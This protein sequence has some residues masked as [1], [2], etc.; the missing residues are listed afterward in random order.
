MDPDRP[1]PAPESLRTP[2]GAL[3]AFAP[4]APRSIVTPRGILVDLTPMREAVLA[5]RRSEHLNRTVVAALEEGV[6]VLD[7]DGTA[8]SVNA[9][10]ERILGI[11][12]ERMLG[13]AFPFPGDHEVVLCDGSPL[14]A[15]LLAT[16]VATGEHHRGVLARL[17]RP[18]S[19]D[20]WLSVN[21]RPLEGAPGEPPIGL[22][23][24]LAD[25]TER[26]ETQARLR[27]ERDRAQHLAYHD[28]LT[29]LPNRIAFDERLRASI[30]RAQRGG[31]ALALLSFDLDNF[32]LVNDSLGHAA[33]DE[34]LRQAAAR[35]RSITRAGD[36][37]ARQ[38][39]DEFL[40]LLDD[41]HTGTEEVAAVVSRLVAAALD[42]PFDVAGAEFTMGASVGISIHPRDGEEADELLK[43]ADAA[44]YDAKR[45]GKG[46]YAFHE[47]G[48]ADP[49][50]RLSLASR[51]RRAIDADE[52]ELHYQPVWD[53]GSGA[54]HG[55][56][57]LVR[58]R[59]PQRGLVLPGDF[60]PLAEE[61][62]LI[63]TI[64]EWVLDALCRQMVTWRA[65][66]IDPAAMSF[67]LS[68]R[69][70][71]RNDVCAAILAALSH[72]G[73]AAGKVCVELTESAAMGRPERT[74]R[75]VRELSEAGLRLAIDD[76]G[77][78][79]SSLTRLGELPFDILKIDRSFLRDVP[80]RQGAA[81]IVSAV[82]EL[83]RALGM[84]TVA[85]G[86]ETEEQLA[87]LA[88][89]GCPLAQGFHLGRPAPAGDMTAL[90]RAARPPAG[91]L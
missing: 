24:S 69:Q 15:E 82:L 5:L 9:S 40:L 83:A 20:V 39:G 55:G 31:G 36:M 17:R 34:V 78:G 51:L 6:I 88:E 11:E 63:V 27:E 44:M 52:L 49:R 23:A 53:L 74:D 71:D 30:A 66:G 22:V 12:A 14:G 48:R 18:G 79:H 85:E 35:L 26:E 25:V 59:D 91:V 89:H 65:E 16:T 73:V 28:R 33:G 50:A 77:T 81:A 1:H 70:L 54:L 84:S 62:G 60:I 80:H 64:G 46:G 45:A 41:L 10:A 3:D 2:R 76:F 7:V 43:A 57:A 86:V 61:T 32:K 37:L 21:L 47:A 38:G 67:N 72:H 29:G 19:A 75:L 58:W 56:E 68:P 8:T 90:L 87:F 4:R 42:P 13:A